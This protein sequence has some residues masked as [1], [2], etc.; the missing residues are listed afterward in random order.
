MSHVLIKFTRRSDGGIQQIILRGKG[1]Q[2]DG[3]TRCEQSSHN[4]RK[5]KRSVEEEDS[6]KE[7]NHNE[8]FKLLK[9]TTTLSTTMQT[10]ID[11]E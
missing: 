2:R 1:Q 11:I 8:G 3:N 10:Q 4:C 6:F 5:R 9:S 7:P